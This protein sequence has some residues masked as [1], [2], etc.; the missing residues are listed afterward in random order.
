M[1]ERSLRFHGARTAVHVRGTAP[2]PPATTTVGAEIYYTTNGTTPTASSTQ[3]STPIAVDAAMT[4]KAI[5]IKA[6]MNNS[7]VLTAAYT[8]T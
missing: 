8:V 1:G 5:A 6:G 7:A 2:E 4:I 3:Y